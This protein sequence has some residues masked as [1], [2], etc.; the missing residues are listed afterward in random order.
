MMMDKEFRPAPIDKLAR[1]IFSDLDQGAAVLGIPRANFAQLDPR[2]AVTLLGKPLGVPLG[3]AAG[4]HTQLA[5]NIVAAWLCGARFMELKTVQVLDSIKVSRPC[6]DAEDVTFNC[7][8]SQELTLEASYREYLHAWVLVHALAH[9]LGAASPQA[10]FNMSV[11]Y[12]LAGIQSEKVQR[13]LRRMSDASAD[14]PELI[15][16]VA[17]VYPPVREISIPANLSTM[18]TLSTMHGCPPQEI[19]RIARYLLTD[20]GVHTWV[21]L[22]PTLLG[23]ERLRTILNDRLGFDITVP[24]SAFEHDPRFEDAM[25]MVTHLRDAAR[26]C[27]RSFGVK[28]SNTLEVVNHRTVFAPSEKCMYM[29]GRAL[30]PLTLTLAHLVT[31]ALDGSVPLSFCGGADFSSFASLLADGLGP[32]T[33]CTDLLKP[34]G[35]ARLHQYVRSLSRSL[36]RTRVQS[37]DEFVLRTAGTRAPSEVS[38][39]ARHNLARHAQQVLSGSRHARRRV[40]SV[41]KGSRRLDPYD[42]I[43]APCQEGCPAHQNIPDYLHWIAK[44]EF[45]KALEVILHT[46]PM[47]ATTGRVCDHP[48]TLRCVR[49]HYD[50]PLA[51]RELK[52]VAEAEAGASL[53]DPA[54]PEQRAAVAVIGGG[55]A[56]LSAARSLRLAGFAVTVFETRHQPGGMASS[57][58]PSYRL[59]TAS[60]A[61]DLERIKATGA[62]IRTGDSVG[63]SRNLSALL[64][65]GYKY[66]VIA[67]GAQLGRKLGIPGEDATGVFD[68]LDLLS[69]V[70]AGRPPCIGS[71]TVVVGGGNSAMDAARTALRLAGVRSVTVAYRRKRR[72][73]PAEIEEIEQC[74]REGAHILDLLA[75]VQVL[76][77]KGKVTG[78]RCLRMQ[79]GEPD[80]SGR[81][82]PVPIPDSETLIECDS[83]IVA[84]SQ[85]PVVGFA[86]ELNLDRNRDGT[87]RVDP[88]TGATSASGVFAAG[89]VVRGPSTV[90]QAIADGRAVAAA[91]AARE[92]V[93]LSGERVLDKKLSHASC[94]ERKARI[95]LPEVAAGM[96]GIHGGR[97]ARFGEVVP[98]LDRRTAMLEASRC[99]DCDEVCSLCVTVCPNRANQ[100]YWIE[101]FSVQQPT[102]VYCNGKL[103]LR[104]STRF[105]VRQR[106]Q[107]LNIADFCNA[108]GNCTTFCPTSGAPYQDKP[109]FHLNRQAFHAADYDAYLVAQRGSFVEIEGKIAGRRHTVMRAGRSIEYVSDQ[110]AARWDCTSYDFVDAIASAS[111]QEGETVDLSVATRMIPLLWAP[112][113]V[114]Y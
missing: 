2:T 19:E 14:L 81:P 96:P 82:R 39:A 109:R 12:D 69:R 100:A 59:P 107:I 83:I 43:A 110:L 74:E 75:P 38:M 56:G 27:G 64:Q 77:S 80:G 8:W 67:V 99:L 76:H 70:S 95:A 36:D 79:L 61:R 98:T 88:V 11:G 105:E 18:V 16:A 23:P 57:V 22:N 42:C 33:V 34:G 85:E 29:S 40:P 103:D 13:Y 31:E 87:I 9:R 97:P 30:H 78:L 90:I 4:P 3:V 108:C 28:L 54:C 104:T 68:S 91:I 53:R 93:Q 114:P 111:L 10:I 55:P 58:I 86:Q 45:E 1:W 52:R 101:P 65:A 20:F 15:D 35:Y 21:K 44:G 51:I 112:N 73:M 66:C 92:G 60:L 63:E 50:T 25:Q 71:R 106:I 113:T 24:D 7:E 5:Q 102:L 48:C 46:N 47:P 89:D 41:P 94:L 26:D 84:I 32:V 37:L 6:I 72:H 49:N 17:A 62:V